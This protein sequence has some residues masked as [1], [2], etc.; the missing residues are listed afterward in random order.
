MFSVVHVLTLLTAFFG[1][2]IHAPH[3]SIPGAQMDWQDKDGITSLMMAAERGNTGILELLLS[4]GADIHITAR[5]G[6]TAAH[7][8][9]KHGR[10]ECLQRLLEAG[11]SVIATDCLGRMLIH[12]AAQQ[13]QVKMVEMLLDQGCP[14]NGGQARIG[15]RF[16]DRSS[17]IGPQPPLASTVSCGPAGDC[18]VTGETPLHTAVKYGRVDTVKL[19]LKNRAG[20][21]TV[22]KDGSTPLHV[23]CSSDIATTAALQEIGAILLS[24]KNLNIQAVD[25]FGKSALSYTKDCI[26]KGFILSTLQVDHIPYMCQLGPGCAVSSIPM[27]I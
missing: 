14:V 19:L 20:I 7:F 27:V 4:N 17:Q 6:S 13:G 16:R 5:D 24:Q 10:M 12:W 25:S 26:L 1:F 9:A 23:C 15:N 18:H 8:A 2:E 3:C 22:T 11:S 21:N